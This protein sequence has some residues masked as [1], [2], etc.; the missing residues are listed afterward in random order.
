[1]AWH[2]VVNM[3]VMA[4]ASPSRC[5]DPKKRRT[6]SALIRIRPCFHRYLK[7][8]AAELGVP[9]YRLLEDIV[10]KEL[11]SQRPWENKGV[12]THE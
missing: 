11:G 4:H 3:A 2:V 7:V 8:R 1:V 6:D 12:P 9:V 5:S 10:A